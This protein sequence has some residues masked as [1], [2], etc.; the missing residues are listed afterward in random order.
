MCLGPVAMAPF[1]SWLCGDLGR[2]VDSVLLAKM[3]AKN[4][5]E[6]ARMGEAIDDAE[7]NFGESE[8]K[9]ALMAKAEYLCKIGDKVREGRGV[10][11][12]GEP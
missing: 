8:R 7:K 10:V 3:E 6:L 5:V 9:D 2:P 1:Y 11:T 12:K 4:K